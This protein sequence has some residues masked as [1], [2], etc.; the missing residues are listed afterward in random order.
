M[1]R[2]PVSLRAGLSAT[3]AVVLASGVAWLLAHDPSRSG[4]ASAA[5]EI[6]GGAAMVLLVLLGAVSALHAPAAWREGKNRWSGAAVVGLVSVLILTGFL[7]YYLGDEHARG[8][9]SIMHW[10][11]GL[12]AGALLGLH[13]WLGVRAAKPSNCAPRR[14]PGVS[15]RAR[16]S[17]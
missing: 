8:F 10:T 2:L 7:L 11:V 15:A 13:V 4:F 17:P 3:G 9:A 16:S 1:R 12:A 5:M 6:H 14:A